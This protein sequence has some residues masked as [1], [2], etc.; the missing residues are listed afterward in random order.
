MFE[1]EVQSVEER[2]PRLVP[3]AVGRLKVMVAPEPVMLKSVPLVEVAKRAVPVV[4]CPAGPSARTPV[5]VIDGATEPTTVKEVQETPEEQVAE[6]VATE[7]RA[8]VP[9]PYTSWEEVKD[10]APVPPLDTPSVPESEGA[11]VK[12]PE[13][14]VMLRPSVRPVVAVEV[15]AKVMAPVCA[16]P[17]PSCWRERRP[18]LVM[19]RPEPMMDCPAVTEIPVPLDTVPV[20]ADE[21]PFVPLPYRIW[22]EVKVE[23]PVPPLFT[24]RVP[25]T[26]VRLMPREEVAYPMN[27]L[28]GP[29]IKSEEEAIDVRPVPPPRTESVPE[30]VGV[31]VKA[32]EV[33]VMLSPMVTPLL[34]TEEVA[35]VMAP[36]CAEPKVCARERRPALE[37]VTAPVAPLTLM[38]VPATAEVTKLEEVAI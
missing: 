28:P 22:P 9:F 36:V 35:K 24:V 38:P 3:E 34:V 29:P 19:V 11:K 17:P 32:P 18:V 4:V 14:L 13:E 30:R 15:V 16:V 7:V 23:T 20:A 25:V 27:V 1:K 21:R 33:L 31:K 5:L 12:A 2:R 37:M 10:C 26:S 8:P 6:D